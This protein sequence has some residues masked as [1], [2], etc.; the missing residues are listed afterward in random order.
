MDE[1]VW[2]EVDDGHGT[3]WRVDA[4][5]LASRW[6]CTWG[7][8]CEGILEVPAAHLGQ[9]CCSVGAELLDD[10]EAQRIAALAATLEPERFELHEEAA[11]GGVLRAEGERLATRV[12]DG[13]CVFLNRPGFPGGPGCALHLA[14]HDDGESPLDWKPAVC[15]QLPLK[16]DREPLA[17]GR[18]RATLRPWRRTDWGEG[19]VVHWCCTEDDGAFVGDAAVVDS[20]AEEVRALV[21]PEVHVELRRRLGRTIEE[22]AGE[23]GTGEAGISDDQRFRAA[24]DAMQ[25]HVAIGVALRDDEGRIVDFVLTFLNAA[26]VDGAGR[27]GHELVG[28]RVLEL[29]PDWAAHGLFD[30]FCAVVETG[31]PYLADRVRYEGVA[32]DG[33]PIVGWWSI[34]AVRLGDGYLASS[35]DITRQVESEQARLRD[36]LDAARHRQSVELLQRAALPVSLPRLEGLELGAR[37]QPAAR[38]QPVGGDW[39]DAF[40]LDDQRVALVIADVAGHG[41]EAAAVMVQVRNVVRALALEHEDPATVLGR[42]DAVLARMVDH[43]LYA[44]C[45]YAVLDVVHRTARWARAGHLHPILLGPEPS[46]LEGPGG[47]PLGVQPGPTFPV[48]ERSFAPGTGLLLCTDGLVEARGV[49]VDQGLEQL[50]AQVATEFDRPVQ[51]LADGLADAIAEP[52]DDL[53]VLVARFT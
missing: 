39:Y 25:D 22:V 3:L 5:F 6:T 23:A 38:A 53:A 24:L 49:S 37:Y 9:G 42:A 28:G 31:A 30:A 47:A 33:R 16:V 40:A 10:E 11:A 34:T 52:A 15:W 44:T 26:S 36:E 21:G 46:V 17:D 18:Q 32:D 27:P 13:A 29:F 20:L 7:R 51:A 35:R 45:C 48:S 1:P 4:T 50:A 8:G 19:A 2:E 43:D 12:V 41:P 14:A